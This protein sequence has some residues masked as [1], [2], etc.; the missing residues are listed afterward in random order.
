M[1]GEYNVKKEQVSF[2]WEENNSAL[3]DLKLYEV[4][5][6]PATSIGDTKLK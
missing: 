6:A 5:D 2:S 4:T 1:H 3:I